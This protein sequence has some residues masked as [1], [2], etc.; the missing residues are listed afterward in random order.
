MKK[1]YRDGKPFVAFY[2]VE[3]SQ[4]QQSLPDWERMVVVDVGVVFHY[5]RVQRKGKKHRDNL[6]KNF[7]AN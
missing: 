2:I 5:F 7:I 1:A 3:Y 6:L 4:Y